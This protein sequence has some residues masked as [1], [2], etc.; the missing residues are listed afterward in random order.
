MAYSSSSL[1][2]FFF[3]LTTL[4]AYLLSQP[5]IKMYTALWLCFSLIELLSGMWFL[6]HLKLA[7]RAVSSAYAFA[8]FFAFMIFGCIILKDVL[9]VAKKDFI[10]W[11]RRGILTF[12]FLSLQC[13]S[14]F[15]DLH[16]YIRL[17]IALLFT[18]IIW[19]R[20]WLEMPEAWEKKSVHL[21]KTIKTALRLN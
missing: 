20:K 9:R 11:A 12:A 2:F 5:R 8:A 13:A 16:I 6:T 19:H 18:F 7:L 3:L 21:W 14:L 17:T 15:Y 4:S 10:F 1:D